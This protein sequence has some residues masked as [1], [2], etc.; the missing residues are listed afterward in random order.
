MCRCL[1]GRGGRC[2]VWVELVRRLGL[3]FTNTVRTG[4]VCVMCLVA[5]GARLASFL[6]PF[7]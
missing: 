7:L 5:V 2:V 4:G 1:S 6:I 3:G